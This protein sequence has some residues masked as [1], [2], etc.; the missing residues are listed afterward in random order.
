MNRKEVKHYF[1]YGKP[2][3]AFISLESAITSAMEA[4][5]LTRKQAEEDLLGL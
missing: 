3:S 2:S 4:G 5:L 1:E